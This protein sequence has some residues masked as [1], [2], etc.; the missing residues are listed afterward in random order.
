MA[1]V[2]TDVTCGIEE[3]STTA[4]GFRTAKRTQVEHKSQAIT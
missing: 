3:G 1:N 4:S 2:T